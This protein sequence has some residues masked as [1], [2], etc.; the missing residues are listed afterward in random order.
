MAHNLNS[1]LTEDGAALS[2]LFPIRQA[3][4][5]NASRATTVVTRKTRVATRY[6]SWIAV[7]TCVTFVVSPI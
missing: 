1:L 4:C 6:G 5:T 2:Q 7:H 3:L